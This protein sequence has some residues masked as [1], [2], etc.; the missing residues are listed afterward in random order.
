MKTTS[1]SR[2]SERSLD[3]SQ[4]HDRTPKM[5]D[6]EEKLHEQS[7]EVIGGAETFGQ[8]ADRLKKTSQER[9]PSQLKSYSERVEE[10]KARKQKLN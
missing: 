1:R 6:I 3:I 4:L 10:V 7:V 8:T 9:F 5:E 2:K